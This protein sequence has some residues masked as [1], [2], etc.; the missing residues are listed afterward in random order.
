[1]KVQNEA[2]VTAELKGI[3][4][5]AQSLFS[6]GGFSNASDKQVTSGQSVANADRWMDMQMFTSQPMKKELSGLGLEYRLIQIY[7][8]DAGRRG[9]APVSTHARAG[10]P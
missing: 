2:G 9:T 7:S 4:P 6:G 5:H 8:R 1:M 10:V 3:S